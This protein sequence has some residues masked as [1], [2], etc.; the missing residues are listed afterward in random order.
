ML[1]VDAGTHL[2]G[3]I[4]IL[5]EHFP[6]A[7]F[8]ETSQP[9]STNPTVISSGP[10]ANL[11]LPYQSAGA[12]GAY[13]IRD[14]IATYLI[15]HSHLDHISGL[16]INT[17]ALNSPKNP[18][19]VAALPS[20]IDAIKDHIFNDIIWP[21]LSDENGGAGLVTFMRLEET[22][23]NPLENK[24]GRTYVEL[25]DGLTVNCWSVSHGRCR[26]KRAQNGID[27][28]AKEI[29]PSNKP[30]TRRAS[31]LTSSS[32]KAEHPHPNDY[33]DHGEKF[34]AYNSAA[35]FLRDL[36]TGKEALI[37]GDVEPD[38]LS[39]WPR[40]ARVWKEAATKVARGTLTGILIECSF[41]NSQPD[42]HLYGHLTPHHLMIELHVLASSV[43]SLQS[44]EDMVPDRTKRRKRAADQYGLP[45]PSG[46]GCV[47]G[48]LRV[49]IT[50]VKNN[51]Q[52]GPAVQDT[53]LTQLQDLENK[54]QLGV[55]FT[56][57]KAG[58]SIWL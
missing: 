38:S 18:K 16:V 23:K 32:K 9:D 17:A 11:E 12:N 33:V 6:P 8:R 3:I 34:C 13:M 44:P 51:L 55:V 56:M 53:I 4:K 26:K 21:N 42:E 47:L 35:Y 52:D 7:S 58:T 1:A 36:F 49:I 25:C 48:G 29:I 46:V 15:T 24:G 20:T 43:R 50:H 22:E 39:L 45:S 40:T 54:A 57:S 31:R 37:V 5:E 28:G 27:A 14:L 19:R 10:F 41:P 2:A 30:L